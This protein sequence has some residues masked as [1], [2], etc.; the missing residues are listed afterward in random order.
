MAHLSAFQQAQ[1]RQNTGAD[2][3]QYEPLGCASAAV[4]NLPLEP[5]KHPQRLAANHTRKSRKRLHNRLASP[6]KDTTV[7]DG[8]SVQRNAYR[9]LKRYLQPPG[10][11]HYAASE[12]ATTNRAMSLDS[13]LRIEE[14]REQLALHEQ[15]SAMLEERHRTNDA[16]LHAVAADGPRAAPLLFCVATAAFVALPKP[17]LRRLLAE[18]NAAVWADIEQVQRHATRIANQLQLEKD[19]AKIEAD[20]ARTQ[21]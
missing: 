11:L 13:S 10:A 8:Q 3:K 16:A 6:I 12:S 7:T 1:T 4:H 9:A 14:L 2:W 5:C 17:A 20:A 15:H 21:S 18:E 19:M